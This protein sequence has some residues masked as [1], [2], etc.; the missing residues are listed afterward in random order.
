MTDKIQLKIEQLEKLMV[1]LTAAHQRMLDLLEQ[2]RAAFRQGRSEVLQRAI[3]NEHD[4]FQRIAEMEKRRLGLV[5]ELTMLIDPSAAEPMT[6]GDLADRLDEPARGRLRVLRQQ[7][8]DRIEQ[9]RQQTRLA[10]SSAEAMV[11]HMKGLMHTL[12]GMV[13]G[14]ATYNQ[15]GTIPGEKMASSTFA[16]TA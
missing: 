2:K 7:L 1:E 16:A 12:G 3:A 6:L 14:V 13:T 11:E 8:R 5:A 10:R 9:T 4:Q 15:R